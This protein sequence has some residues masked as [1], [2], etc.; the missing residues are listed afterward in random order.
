ME[1]LNSNLERSQAVLEVNLNQTKVEISTQGLLF[2][3]IMFSDQLA[4][5]EQ[6]YETRI[7]VHSHRSCP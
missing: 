2:I 1:C 6:W 5:K 3:L 4:I 7:E